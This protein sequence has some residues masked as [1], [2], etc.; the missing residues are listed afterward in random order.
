MVSLFGEISVSMIVLS[1]TF[2]LTGTNSEEYM[3]LCRNHLQ[4][5]IEDNQEVKLIFQQD[6]A[7]VRTSRATIDYSMASGS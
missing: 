7:V 4:S 2:Q 3:G 1:P 5:F 6:N